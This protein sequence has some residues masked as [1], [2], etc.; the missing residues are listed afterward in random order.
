MSRQTTRFKTQAPSSPR[1]ISLGGEVL[2]RNSNQ[3]LVN[4]ASPKRKSVEQTKDALF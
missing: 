1:Y 4:T 3:Y 2:S